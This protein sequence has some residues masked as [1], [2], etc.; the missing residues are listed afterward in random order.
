MSQSSYADSQETDK[1]TRSQTSVVRD[2]HGMVFHLNGQGNRLYPAMSRPEH[3]R[4]KSDPIE[5]GGNIPAISSEEP[6]Q[7]NASMRG[8]RQDNRLDR[9]H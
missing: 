3:Y 4:V 9:A 8:S 5:P 1:T 6:S 2:R 7:N